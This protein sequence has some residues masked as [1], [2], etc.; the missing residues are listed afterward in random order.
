MNRGPVYISNGMKWQRITLIGIL[1]LSAFLHGYRLSYPDT[2]VFDEMHF[3]TYAADYALGRPFVDIHPPLGKVLYAVPL[4]LSLHG[5]T[6]ASFVNTRFDAEGERMAMDLN[7]HPFGTLPYIA[8]RLISVFFGLL[9][10]VAVYAFLAALTGS[11]TAGV[12][13]AAFIAFDN[14][15]LLETRTILL[16]GM[17]LSLAFGSLALLFKKKAAPIL[18]G[19][20]FGLA[21]GVKLIAGIFALPLCLLV[22]FHDV[23][24]RTIRPDRRTIIRFLTTG[25]AVFAAIVLF[26]NNILLPADGR[27]ALYSQFF[28]KD[29]IAVQLSS[30]SEKLAPIPAPL[31]A[32]FVSMMELNISF[33]GYTSGA[34][35]HPSQSP[36]YEWPLMWKPVFFYGTGIGQPLM[37]LT[38]NPVVWGGALALTLFGAILTAVEFRRRRKSLSVPPLLFVWF[39]IMVA[40]FA[41]VGRVTFL[42]HYFPA[43]LFSICI[44]AVLI[45][46]FL[47]RQPKHIRVTLVI[48]GVLLL[49]YGFLLASPYT[50][51]FGV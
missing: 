33:T 13:A 39:L 16:D 34:A 27:I 41:L 42:Y 40:P 31:K 23:S 15:F 49:S 35:S 37:T 12:I 11:E 2:P 21:V 43:L 4:V 38:G 25:V 1:L 5:F 45:G 29:P 28:P 10:I 8:L 7:W 30:S 18:G 48:A 44:A 32:A 20:V 46:G 47:A 14:A 3:A 6:D 24:D 9:L 50:Y 17:Y 19:I 22:I 51:G 36:W 26:M